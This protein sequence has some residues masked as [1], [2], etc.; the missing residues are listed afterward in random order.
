MFADELKTA[1]LGTRLSGRE[2][3]RLTGISSAYYSQLETGARGEPP[4]PLKTKLF[5]VLI[6]STLQ[7][8]GSKNSAPLSVEGITVDYAKMKDQ[9]ITLFHDKLKW[10]EETIANQKLVIEALKG[11]IAAL[12]KRFADWEKWGV[13]ITKS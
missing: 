9:V 10:Q 8:N 11:Q 13:P 1:R 7:A 5:E 3:A 4:E 6:A 2:V 12:E